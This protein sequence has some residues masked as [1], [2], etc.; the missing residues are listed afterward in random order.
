MTE[1]RLKTTTTSSTTTTTVMMMMQRSAMHFNLYSL[2]QAKAAAMKLTGALVLGLLVTSTLKTTQSVTSQ[3]DDVNKAVE[4]GSVEG[5]QVGVADAPA[6]VTVLLLNAGDITTESRNPKPAG[7]TTTESRSPKPEDQDGVG[8]TEA[9]KDESVQVTTRRRRAVPTKGA[10]TQPPDVNENTTSIVNATDLDTNTTA[11]PDLDT[12]TTT[13]ETTTD[14]DVATTTPSLNVLLLNDLVRREIRKTQGVLREEVQ[15]TQYL[16]RQEVWLI[17]D[18]LI[19][20][21]SN[22]NDDPVAAFFVCRK[23]I[24]VSM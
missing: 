1:T 6:D 24:V 19:A 14:L 22:C 5:M 21:S 20:K 8:K 13:V 10:T 9:T 3:T 16:L 17:S 4:P 12:N 18:W 11:D 7:E 15:K 23:F 2:P